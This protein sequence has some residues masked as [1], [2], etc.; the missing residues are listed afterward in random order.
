MTHHECVSQMI[1]LAQDGTTCHM[2]RVKMA[3]GY[4]IALPDHA[5]RAREDSEN[6]SISYNMLRFLHVLFAT[7]NVLVLM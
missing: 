1:K 4:L 2:S 3:N 5:Y 6:L 7:H